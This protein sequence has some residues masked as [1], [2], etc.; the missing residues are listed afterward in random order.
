MGSAALAMDLMAVNGVKKRNISYDRYNPWFKALQR[1]EAGRVW[2][3]RTTR[4]LL[5]QAHDLPAWVKDCVNW[6]AV[7]LIQD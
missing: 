5:E 6:E 4:I 2:R 3:Y 7:S 1:L